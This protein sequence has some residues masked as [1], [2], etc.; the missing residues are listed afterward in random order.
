MNKKHKIVLSWVLSIWIAFVFVQ[1]LFFKFANSPETQHIFGTI[2]NWM[3]TNF[4]AFMGDFFIAYGGYIVGTIELIAA[5]LVIIPRFRV[6]GAGIAV[7]VM[8][9]AIFFH[10]FTPLGIEVQGDSGTLFIMAN[11]VLISGLILVYMHKHQLTK[12]FCKKKITN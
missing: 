2:G 11:T 6:W 8:I 12:V 1:S 7:D 9:G 5:I 3:N 10:L 4:L